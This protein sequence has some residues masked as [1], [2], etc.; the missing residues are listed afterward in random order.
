MISPFK[1]IY[2]YL[3]G[4]RETHEVEAQLRDVLQSLQSYRTASEAT[5]QSGKV[6]LEMIDGLRLPI[7]NQDAREL[8][9][10]WIENS[11]AIADVLA[12]VRMFGAE[13]HDLI[14]GNYEGFMEKVLT[15]KPIVHDFLK[16][17]GRNYNPRT[18]ELNLRSLP[19]LLRIYGQKIGLKE[20]K[21]KSKEVAETRKAVSRALEKSRAIVNQRPLPRVTDRRL[22]R[23]ANEALRKLARESK[24]MQSTK[25]T[26]KLLWDNAPSWFVEI[27]DIGEEVQKAL[28][29]LSRP[30]ILAYRQHRRFAME[31]V[32]RF[33]PVAAS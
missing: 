25:T 31:R 1:Q 11:R 28:P 8:T 20:S 5:E 30:V 32:Q 33:P 4:I 18:G 14:S 10:G 9:R 29:E 6:L 19:T 16:F 2:D 15:R 24:S 13:C 21:E 3:E 17:F 7:S 12:S 22:I 27:L 26:D 23:D